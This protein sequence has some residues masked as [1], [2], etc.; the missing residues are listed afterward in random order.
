MRSQVCNVSCIGVGGWGWGDCT[1]LCFS[2]SIYFILIGGCNVNSS[3]DWT[4]SLRVRQRH[5]TH[6]SSHRHR[7][8][9]AVIGHRCCRFRKS[10]SFPV[11]KP[12]PLYSQAGWA[13]ENAPPPPPQADE[14]PVKRQTVSTSHLNHQ[15]L[16]MT[17]VQQH[18]WL[19]ACI[20][21]KEAQTFQ[22]SVSLNVSSPVHVP[23]SMLT[24]R[25]GG[26][27]FFLVCKDFGRM[28]NHSFL[29]RAFSFFF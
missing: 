16:L 11:A 22:S 21:L 18:L 15:R 17:T 7:D 19:H 25:G 23:F 26:G 20:L 5:G 27:G 13:R 28:F 12:A 1:Y 4:L 24:V 9:Q 2:L 6:K 3:C 10:Q 8:M 14:A 29:A